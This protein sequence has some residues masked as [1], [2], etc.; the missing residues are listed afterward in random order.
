MDSREEIKGQ[1]FERTRRVVACVL[2]LVSPG[3]GHFL[4]GRNRRGV[5]WAVGAPV[6]G[7]GLLVLLPVSFW[8][9]VGI[10][11]FG[12]VTRLVCVMDTGLM[13]A[14]R[15]SWKVVLVAWVAI[16]VGGWAIDAPLRAYYRAHGA[17]GSRF[18]PRGWSRPCS[19]VTTC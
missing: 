2:S 14:G 6:I 17:R 10:V 19:S 5:A 8:T 3:S 13:P 9:L 12:I 15:M 4:L 11:A 18:R 7:L 1:R 16:L